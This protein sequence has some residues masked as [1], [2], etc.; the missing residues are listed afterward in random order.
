M[1]VEDQYLRYEPNPKHKEPWQRGRRGSM[2]PH[3]IDPQE[4]LDGSVFD[5]SNPGKRYATDGCRPYCAQ[6]HREDTWHGYPEQWRD[7]PAKIWRQWL[8]EAVVT[9]KCLK[10][11]W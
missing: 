3:S 5:S 2:C 4:L 6:A 10:E 11:H 1:V 9:K 7:V 8:R